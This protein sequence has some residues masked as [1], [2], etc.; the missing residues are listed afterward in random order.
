MRRVSDLRVLCLWAH[1]SMHRFGG[2][3]SL[4]HFDNGTRCPGNQW[5]D[6]HLFQAHACLHRR[7][8]V[9]PLFS[10]PLPALRFAMHFLCPVCAYP[11]LD[12]PP[13][14]DLIC[15]CCGT[16]FGLDDYAQTPAQLRSAWLRAGANWFSRRTPPPPRWSARRQLAEAGFSAAEGE[17]A[18]EEREPALS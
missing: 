4:R 2:H 5:L 8:S 15:P 16:H 18:G 1:P 3:R 17:E 14:N 12:G 6:P 10:R 11:Q 9:D 7:P 13:R